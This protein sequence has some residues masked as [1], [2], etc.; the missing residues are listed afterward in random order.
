MANVLLVLLVNFFCLSAAEY[1]LIFHDDFTSGSIPDPKNWNIWD[2][3]THGDKEW[4]LYLADEVYLENGAMVIRTRVRDVQY[5]L[6]PYHFTSGWVDTSK[7]FESNYGK[8]SAR[9]K[10]PV[11][12]PGL[13]PAYWLVQDQTKCWPMGGE[14]DIL[15]AVGGLKNDSVFGTYHWGTACGQDA[16][17]KEHR[18]GDFP[19]PKGGHFS[20]DFHNFT[21][22]WNRTVITWEVDGSAYVSRVAGQPQGLFIPSWNLFT[23]FNTALSFWGVP[24]PPPRLGYPA[25]MRVDWVSVWKWSGPGGDTGDFEIPYNGTGLVPSSLASPPV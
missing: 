19:H 9:I 8:Y 18:N 25:F 23:I 1:S 24:Q 20:D 2:N 17:A 10:L 6:K 13:W 14:V 15:E 3:K 7:K 5:G 12:L 21:V 11:E 4:Q 16:W 22:Y